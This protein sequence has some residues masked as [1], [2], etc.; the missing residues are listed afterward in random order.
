MDEKTRCPYCGEIIMPGARKCRHCGEWLDVNETA[1]LKQPEPQKVVVIQEPVREQQA[2]YPGQ[3]PVLIQQTTIERNHSNG[4]GTAG[5]IFALLTILFC[6]APLVKWFLWFL[7]FLLSFIGLFKR[8]RGL[9]IV[10][11][12]LSIIGIILLVALV[13]LIAALFSSSDVSSLLESI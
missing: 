10:G 9:A 5:F 8:P 7:G 6:W 4:A 2:N 13:G 3:Q 1:D 11:F 12:I